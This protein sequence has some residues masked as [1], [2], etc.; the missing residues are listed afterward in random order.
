VAEK[1]RR[2]VPAM[3]E[4][5]ERGDELEREGRGVSPR[6]SQQLGQLWLHTRE[7][8]LW[9]RAKARG[10]RERENLMISCCTLSSV[11]A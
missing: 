8:L 6:V 9:V 5:C 10:S 3:L 4:E 2:G 1:V 7:S 11:W